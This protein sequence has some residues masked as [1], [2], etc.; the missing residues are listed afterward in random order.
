MGKVSVFKKIKKKRKLPKGE[1][2]AKIIEELSSIFASFFVLKL[3]L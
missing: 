3:N 1:K 2:L